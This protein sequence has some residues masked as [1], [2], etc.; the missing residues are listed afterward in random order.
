MHDF[1]AGA[2]KIGLSG[3]SFS[4]LTIVERDDGA[5]ISDGN[6]ELLLAGIGADELSET[7]FISVEFD[8]L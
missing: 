7:D 6:A 4:D 8:Y 5:L 1:E 2:D 3:V